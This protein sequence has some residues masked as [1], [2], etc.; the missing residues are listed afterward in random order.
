MRKVEGE[1]WEGKQGKV[2][3]GQG[4]EEEMMGWRAGEFCG[5]MTCCGG[6]GGER[7][8]K[9]CTVGH[10]SVSL[11]SGKALRAKRNSQ[12]QLKGLHSWRHCPAQARGLQRMAWRPREGEG[13]S[14]LLQVPDHHLQGFAR[15]LVFF[16]V[17]K[18]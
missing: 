10:A 4:E 5:G 7:R 6:E 3:R 15:L 12:F 2:G 16:S 18:P 14:R 11:P 8:K 9:C 17:F 13:F 1:K